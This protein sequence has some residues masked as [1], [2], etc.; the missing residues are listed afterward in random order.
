MKKHFEV[1]VTLEKTEQSGGNDPARVEEFRDFALG[2]FIHWGCDSP[3]GIEISHP[4]VG[5]SDAVLDRYENE[6]APHFNPRRFDPEDY[7]QLAETVGM[8]YVC[9]TTKHH[10]GFCMFDT[11]TTRFNVMNSR[12][13]RDIVAAFGDAFRRYHL[14]FG[15]YFSPLDFHWLRRNGIPIRFIDDE[16]IPANNPGLMRYNQAQLT[17]LL[18]HYGP[19]DL[20]FFD[21]PPEGLKELTWKLSPRTLVTRGEM[22]TPEQTLPEG[23]LPGAWEACHTLGGQWGWHGAMNCTRSPRELV[24][25]LIATRSR[26]GN[27]LLNVTPNPDGTIP[28]EQDRA[29]R[30]L[31]LWLFWHRE[32][33]YPVRPWRIPVSADGKYAYTRSKDGKTLYV[34]LLDREPFDRG[35]RRQFLIPDVTGATAVEL[36]GQNGKISEHT[37]RDFD[38]ETRFENRP[39]GLFID[40]VRGLRPC[41]QIRYDFPFVF[42]VTL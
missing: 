17:E 14:G 42:A 27:L 26:G 35:Q 24:E 29:L 9:F 38:A 18:T 3:L 19:V 20:M 31:G 34:F 7:A 15:L 12:Y 33:I 16:V 21:G 13:G 28:E 37:P 8:K 39:E 41:G 2:M 22:E 23:V 10:A 4:M 30:E 40:A 36:L 6:L 5:A 1:D 11:A 32:A 25:L